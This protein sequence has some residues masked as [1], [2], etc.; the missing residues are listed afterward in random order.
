M[1]T[2]KFPTHF[3]SLNHFEF[4]R[5]SSPA[6]KTHGIAGPTIDHLHQLFHQDCKRII[7]NLVSG[8]TSTGHFLQNAWCWQG[9]PSHSSVIFT[10]LASGQYFTFSPRF[11]HSVLGLQFF[12]YIPSSFPMSHTPFLF[13]HLPYLP[14]SPII[15][16]HPKNGFLLFDDMERKTSSCS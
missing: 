11:S 14:C 8:F 4:L 13:P 5:Y 12:P 2:L 16:F 3:I 10:V 9:I 7:N 6:F 1:P 15:P